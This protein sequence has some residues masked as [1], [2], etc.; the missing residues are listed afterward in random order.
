VE[1]Y[2]QIARII[3]SE[4]PRGRLVDIAGAGHAVNLEQPARFN[5]RVTD[6]IRRAERTEL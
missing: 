5:T 6:F 4:V 3:A 1:G 2:R